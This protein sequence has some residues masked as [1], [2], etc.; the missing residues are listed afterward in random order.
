MATPDTSAKQTPKRRR[1]SDGSSPGKDRKKKKGEHC[2]ICLELIIDDANSKNKK[3]QDAIY[4][5][6]TCDAWLHRRCAGL[7]KTVFNLLQNTTTPFYCP[8]CQLKSYE[9]VISN[10]NQIWLF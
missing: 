6:G 3:C 4:C 2:P 1:T 8:H 10:L 7:S 9:S 5:E